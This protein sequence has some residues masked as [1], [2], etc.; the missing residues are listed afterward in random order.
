MTEAKYLRSSVSPAHSLR[1]PAAQAAGAK[2]KL[3]AFRGPRLAWALVAFLVL[4]SLFMVWQYHEAKVAVSAPAATQKQANDLVGRV[5]KLILL[6]TDEKPTV[7]AVKDA[8]KLRSQQFYANAQNGDVT[9]VYPRHHKA[10]LY[11][12]SRNIIVNV[13]T[14]TVNQ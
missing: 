14:V 13:A 4:F 6:P 11:R 9:L 3:L 12:P 8:S 2:K 5:G 1:N 10:I 7:I